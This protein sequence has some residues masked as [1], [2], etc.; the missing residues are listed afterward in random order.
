[1]GMGG[2]LLV[3]EPGRGTAT[4]SNVFR[5]VVQGNAS[6]GANT[7]LR[8]EDSGTG[9]TLTSATFGSADGNE[10]KLSAIKIASPNAQP[11]DLVITAKRNGVTMGT[12]SLPGTTS[13]Y[14]NLNLAANASFKNI[15]ELVF[16]GFTATVNNTGGLRLDDITVAAAD[17]IAPAATTASAGSITSTSAELGGEVTDG[18]NA[19]VTER[20]I[21]WATTVDPTI[22]NN[23]VSN[24]A[25]LGTF[26]G[27]V[28]S[29]PGMTLIHY[30]SY[31]TIVPERPTEPI[32][33]LRH[34]ELSRFICYPSQVRLLLQVLSCHGPP[35]VK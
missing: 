3:P 30:R 5:V 27:T 19:T 25:G 7:W 34:S 21:V 1:M 23:K 15:D 8:I 26:S 13:T 31:A 6:G 4:V 29:L 2:L 22:S 14:Q 24:G 17:A 9:V 28:S 12:L 11:Q 35:R 32:R 16:S 33:H 10:F 18:G 20:G